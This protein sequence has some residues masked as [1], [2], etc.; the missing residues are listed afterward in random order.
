M[1][2]DDIFSTEDSHQQRAN[3][4]GWHQKTHCGSALMGL[5]SQGHG[6]FYAGPRGGELSLTTGTTYS[7]S[8]I[9]MNSHCT[10]QQIQNT[11]QPFDDGGLGGETVIK[12]S[13]QQWSALRLR[14][15]VHVAQ[16]KSLTIISSSQFL[17]RC[18]TFSPIFSSPLTHFNNKVTNLRA[19]VCLMHLSSL[20]SFSPKH[21]T[22]LKPNRL[23]VAHSDTVFSLISFQN[24]DSKNLVGRVPM[25][26][27]G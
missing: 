4:K 3:K 2:H 24:V 25:F 15:F 8:N 22:T 27:K 10:A 14:R 5:R 13:F 26:F 20:V 18:Q 11:L 17:I 16:M 6:L 1:S 9:V 12:L 21:S 19:A 23:V 7:E